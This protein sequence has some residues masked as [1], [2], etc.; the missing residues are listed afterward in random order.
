MKLQVVPRSHSFDLSVTFKTLFTNG[1][2]SS[3][4]LISLRCHHN[5]LESISA[6]EPAKKKDLDMCVNKLESISAS[7]SAK[8]KDLDMCVNKLESISASEPAKK[9]DLDMCVNKL[10]SIS[11]SEPAKKRDLDMCVNL[12]NT[13]KVFLSK[14]NPNM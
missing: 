10:E 11:A 4:P 7:E 3:F 9:K 2:R 5:K 6:S 12:A 14:I 1:C 8:K 13:C